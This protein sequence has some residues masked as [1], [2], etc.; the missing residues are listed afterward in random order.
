MNTAKN[1]SSFGLQRVAR[2]RLVGEHSRTTLTATEATQK[3]PFGGLGGCLLAFALLFCV[4]TTATAQQQLYL[5][6]ISIEN[7]SFDREESTTVIA[8]DINL[9]GLTINRNH[10]L[11]ITPVINSTDGEHTVELSPIYIVGRT[12]YR[13]LNR[14]F[15][16]EGKTELSENALATVVRTNRTHQLIRYADNL[17]FEEWQ[18]HAQLWLR[19]EIVGCA[20]CLVGT[21]EKNI[22]DRI[23]PERFV[24]DFRMALILPDPE[25]PKRRSEDHSAHFNFPVGRHDLLPNFGNNAAELAAVDR[26]I[27]ELMTNEDLEITYFVI[28]GF[29]SPEGSRE[30]NLALSQRRAET[31]AHYIEEAYGFSHEKFEVRWYGEDWDGLRRAVAASS[32]PNRDAII[33]IIDN[34]P[35]WDERDTHLRALDNGYTYNLLLNQFY[36]PLRRNDYRIAFISRPFETHEAVEV[37]ETRPHYLN[38]IEMWGVAKLHPDGSAE[39][40]RIFDIAADTFPEEE[41][42]NLNAAVLELQHNNPDAA[43]A[44]LRNITGESAKAQNLRGIAYAMKGENQQARTA[45]TDAVRLGDTTARHNLEQL[46]MYIADQ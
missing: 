12:R 44:R 16:W 35:N 5:D 37:I 46:E 4:F 21:D 39:Q 18:R 42:A 24:P 41:V 29:A 25:I 26:I 2:L 13:V 10:L 33:N 32:L 30:S 20:D 22:I 34:V 1:I 14:P 17:P 43:I 27:R 40:K 6:Q 36:P 7:I 3:P 45:F 38:L 31:F 9:E 8:M 28:S 19:T 23:F 15:T 11:K